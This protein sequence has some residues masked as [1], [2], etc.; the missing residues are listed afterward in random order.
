M[1]LGYDEGMNALNRFPTPLLIALIP[2]L[3]L[4]AASFQD[5]TTVYAGA[6]LSAL[7][8]TLLAAGLLWGVLAL[9]LRGRVNALWARSACMAI[10]LIILLGSG[11]G[12]FAA[13]HE[14]LALPGL[15]LTIR[16]PAIFLT[17][18]VCVTI[19]AMVTVWRLS[20]QRVKALFQ[21][22]TAY[23]LIVLL[24]ALAPV[25][26]Q[27]AQGPGALKP[28]ASVETQATA[29]SATGV[30][31][32]PDIY[33]LILD[34]YGNGAMLQR[35]LHFD[36]TPFLKA[37]QA[38]GFITTPHSTSNYAQT[39]LSIPSMLNMRYLDAERAIGNAQQRADAL[40]NALQENAVMREAREHGYRVI[41]FETAWGLT[42]DLA[43]A[44]L[45]M[46]CGGLN[47][48]G[49]LMLKQT[50][51]GLWAG[52]LNTSRRAI[53]R[54]PFE[55]IP[56]LAKQ[57]FRKFVF[58]HIVSPHMPYLFDAAGNPVEDTHNLNIA[59]ESGTQP[60]P[61][62]AQ[63]QFIN[64]QVLQLV[65]RIL[66]TSE[67]PPII[68]IVSDHGTASQ[69]PKLKTWN[70]PSPA[71]LQE[72]M[73]NLGLFYL[74]PDMRAAFDPPGSPVN[75]FRSVYRQL[76]SAD[77][78]PLPDRNWYSSYVEDRRWAFM[79]VSAVVQRGR[80]A[81]RSSSPP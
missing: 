27:L 51:A 26:P 43:V 20:E 77:R 30:A 23:A 3:N 58:A 52:Q 9:F 7:G 41:S 31:S 34:E 39:A 45:T 46:R 4:L 29:V 71:M 42:A 17:L 70:T 5:V 38:R 68:L 54:C 50:L 55:R 64:T 32:L 14:G 47:E 48:F 80:P 10:I 59:S 56:D 33:F 19:A 78:P 40:K 62:L 76:W 25:L 53:I 49:Y 63:L 12:I 28:A 18:A 16:Q 72:R 61:Y 24:G 67:H 66:A 65:D 1:P 2:L 13:L 60:G 21:W 15:K 73:H 37:M 22:V 44:D 35:F 75:L 69:F 6:F 74:P 57:P 8:I 11:G 36:N 79:D 81:P